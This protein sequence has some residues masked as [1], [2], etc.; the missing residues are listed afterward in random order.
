M[1]R[2]RKVLFRA[3]KA[4]LIML[5]IWVLN[6]SAQENNIVRISGSRY[7]YFNLTDLAKYYA[8][9][10]PEAN[11][12]VTCA[13]PYSF[14]TS[15]SDKTSDAIM[16]LGKL[17]DD[18]KNEAAELGMQLH[19]QLV[20]WGAV[21][22][23]TDPANPVDYLTLEQVRKIFLGEYQN[24]KEVGGS[25]EP[26]VTMS[27]DESVSGTEKFFKE[28]VLGGFPM[29]QQTV[30]LFDPDIVRAVRARKG[31][32]ADARYTEA[33]RGRIKGMVKIIGIKEDEGSQAVMPSVDTIRNQSYPLSTPLF[34]YYDVRSE[35][36]EV[37]QFVNF[38]VRRGLGRQYAEAPGTAALK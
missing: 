36:H 11:V 32:I 20:G 25:D 2:C 15:M 34:L 26:I 38:C 6:V 23:V 7:M 17:D 16:A 19:E 13:E 3:I 4:M 27:R 30:R 8:E 37:K 18:L 14:L 1:N 12:S 9:R 21:V 35:A 22:M 28:F 10:R 33:I 29:W 5:I 31:S 24:W